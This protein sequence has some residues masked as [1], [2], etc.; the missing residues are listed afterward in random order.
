MRHPS[1]FKGYAQVAAAA[2]WNAASVMQLQ[3]QKSLSANSMPS[4]GRF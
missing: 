3:D 2:Q 4:L 1:E